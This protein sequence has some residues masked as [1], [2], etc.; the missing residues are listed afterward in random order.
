MS[1]EYKVK[2][3]WSEST[4]RWFYYITYRG[5]FG[6]EKR[7]KVKRGYYRTERGKPVTNENDRTDYFYSEEDATTHVIKNFASDKSIVRIIQ[8]D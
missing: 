7:V 2:K 1:R 3:L 4:G 6:I 5:L 8:I